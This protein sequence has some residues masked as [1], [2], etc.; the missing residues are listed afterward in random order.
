M[1]GC[2]AARTREPQAVLDVELAALGGAEGIVQCSSHF[3]ALGVA[4]EM[5]KI[6]L[7]QKL[8]LPIWL[9]VA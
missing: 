4:V 6:A 9:F 3:T 1:L 5:E 2:L 7:E 8:W